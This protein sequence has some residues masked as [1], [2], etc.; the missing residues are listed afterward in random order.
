[1][2]DDEP[3]VILSEAKDLLFAVHRFPDG[4]ITG[5]STLAHDDRDGPNQASGIT[6][7]NSDLST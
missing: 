5:E 3:V 2:A 1:M 6:R 4:H 7:M